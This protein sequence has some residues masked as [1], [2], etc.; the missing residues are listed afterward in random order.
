MEQLLRVRDLRTHFYTYRG[1]VRALN[2]VNLTIPVKEIVGLV[3]ETGSGKSVT[4]RSIIRLIDS[5]GRIIGGEIIFEGMDLLKLRK[6]EMAKVRGKE[7]SMIFQEPVIALNPVLNVGTQMRETLQAN[8][9]Y[10]KKKAEEE[11]V[12]LLTGVG[13][14]DAKSTLKRYPH[15]LSGGMA[16]RVMIAMA[17]SAEP[18]LLIAD[19]PTSSLDV[20][21]QSQILH[22]LRDLMEDGRITSILFITHDLGVAAELCNKI[23]VMYGGRIAE[24]GTLQQIF[25]DPKHPYTIGLMKAVPKLGD[26]ERLYTIPGEVPDLV[27]P[28]EGCVFHPRCP[29]AME[30]CRKVEPNTTVVE[31]SHIVSCHLM[32]EN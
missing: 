30:R 32:E 17:I 26:Y 6:E 2:G 24:F 9:G 19:E 8:M 28:P 25:E 15:E 1:V 23:A 11:A 10:N 14:P 31:G 4:A 5:P 29:H 3:G 27:S 16:Q 22:L 13:L 20:T 18:K 12:K 21:I 7:I